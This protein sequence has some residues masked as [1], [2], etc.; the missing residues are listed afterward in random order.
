VIRNDGLGKCLNDRQS[1]TANGTTVDS[2]ACT[3]GAAQSWSFNPRSD[4]YS[5]RGFWGWVTPTG[6]AAGS[7]RATTTRRAS[8][9]V[10][11]V[12]S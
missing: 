1:A 12:L 2:S 6:A 7:T 5:D 4:Y 9:A 3:N 11:T 10:R 8:P